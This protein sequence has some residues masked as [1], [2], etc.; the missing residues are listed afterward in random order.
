MSVNPRMPLTH[1]GIAYL[2]LIV[3]GSLAV[4]YAIILAAGIRSAN[5]QYNAAISLIVLFIGIF[6]CR[7]SILIGLKSRA[8]WS[9]A[10][11]AVTFLAFFLIDNLF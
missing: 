2:F 9:F 1:R 5:T 3:I 7:D 10:L 4:A 6:F 11:A 8:T